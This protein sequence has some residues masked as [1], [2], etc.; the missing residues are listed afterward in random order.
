MPTEIIQM[1]LSE[2]KLGTPLASVKRSE[3]GNDTL[4]V[5]ETISE[6]MLK[7]FRRDN[8]EY[9]IE[10][11]TLYEKLDKDIQRYSGVD[12]I[13]GDDMPYV[14]L[15]TPFDKD[16]LFEWSLQ[17]FGENMD[18]SYRA[19]LDSCDAYAKYYYYNLYEYR[20][21]GNDDNTVTPADFR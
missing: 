15:T 14:L 4:A 7:F 11:P 16:A 9:T 17:L 19:Y 8:I 18:A 10:E 12:E 1:D 5:P 21:D 20:P 6:T 3:S 13:Y 2:V